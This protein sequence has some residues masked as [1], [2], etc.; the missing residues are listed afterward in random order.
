F[1]DALNYAG[2]LFGGKL[3]AEMDL[4]AANSARRLLYGTKFDGLVTAHL[5]EVDFVNPAF[6]GDIVELRTRVSRLGKSSITLRVSAHSESLVGDRTHICEASF[7]M[8]ALKDGKPF[9]H[10]K[11]KL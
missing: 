10:G 7:V 5:S 9:D 11:R 2:T 8:V 3:L 6:L 4:A 1:P